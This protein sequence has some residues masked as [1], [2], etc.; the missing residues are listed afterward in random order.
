[1]YLILSYLILSYLICNVCNVKFVMW[2]VGHFGRTVPS[3]PGRPTAFPFLP[4]FLS[5][6]FSESGFNCSRVI[7]Y[8]LIDCN[9]QFDHLFWYTS[10]FTFKKNGKKSVQKV[11]SEESSFIPHRRTHSCSIEHRAFRNP[12]PNLV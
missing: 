8:L 6:P 9:N 11:E 10:L 4:F 12:S 5:F 1:M 7:L 2:D 3:S